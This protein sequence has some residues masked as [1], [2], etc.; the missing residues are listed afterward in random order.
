M[1]ATR[2]AETFAID[3]RCRGALPLGRGLLLLICP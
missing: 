3:L 1:I 2:K